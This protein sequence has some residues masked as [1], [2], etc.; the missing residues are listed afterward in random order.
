[1]LLTVIACGCADDPVQRL[2][3]WTDI[4]L[5][6]GGANVSFMKRDDMDQIAY[7]ISLDESGER[8]LLD[9]IEKVSGRMCVLFVMQ[10]EGCHYMSTLGH[11]VFVT[12]AAAQRYE[13]FTSG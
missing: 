4:D 3:L 1:M 11:D 12:K 7:S 6:G 13:I 8:R 2:K 9:A 10:G 5:T